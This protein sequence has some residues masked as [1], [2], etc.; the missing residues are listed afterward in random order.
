MGLQIGW[1]LMAQGQIHP[2]GQQQVVHGGHQPQAI[3][4]A[5]LRAGL[6]QSLNKGWVCA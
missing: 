4:V 1:Q 5:Q 6:I 3:A 2:P